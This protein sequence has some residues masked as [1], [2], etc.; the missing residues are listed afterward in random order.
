MQFDRLKRREFIALVG[1]AAVG[2]PLAARAQQRERI[3]RIGV[4]TADANSD[5]DYQ[6]R[7]RVFQ[8]GLR[9]LGWAEGHNIH[10]DIRQTAGNA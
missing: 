7:F 10:I 2:W 3:R 5:L 8:D 4:L 1:A 6:F 9:E